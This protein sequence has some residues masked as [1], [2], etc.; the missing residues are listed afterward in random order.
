MIYAGSNTHILHRAVR[1]GVRVYVSWAVCSLT[2]TPLRRAIR[3]G[4]SNGEI[5]TRIYLRHLTTLASP[6]LD[7]ILYDTK[8]VD[9]DVLVSQSGGERNRILEGLR[10]FLPGD[11]LLVRGQSCLLSLGNFTLTPTMT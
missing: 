11:V 5:G 7:A 8:A 2:E 6:V 9:P 1:I 4:S 10:N 3:C